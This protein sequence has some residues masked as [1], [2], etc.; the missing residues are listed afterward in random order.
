[1]TD[2]PVIPAAIWDRIRRFLST[3]ASGRI[4]LDVR[5]GRITG[6]ALEERID[7]PNDPAALETPTVAPLKTRG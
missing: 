7:T 4:Y 3:G 6:A 5:R 1:M 2:A